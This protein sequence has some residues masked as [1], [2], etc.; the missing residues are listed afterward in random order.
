[1]IRFSIPEGFASDKN[2]Q[3]ILKNISVTHPTLMFSLDAAGITVAVLNIMLWS[4]IHFEHITGDTNL[5]LE[6]I[7]DVNCVESLLQSAKDALRLSSWV[8]IYLPDELNK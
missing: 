7:K 3:M 1:M 6:S 4:P 5:E 2:P 8:Y